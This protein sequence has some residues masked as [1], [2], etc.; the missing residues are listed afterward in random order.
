MAFYTY[1]HSLE[2]YPNT[3][4]TFVQYYFC[5]SARPDLASA[6][7]LT[8]YVPEGIVQKDIIQGGA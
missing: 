6:P 7:F 2:I 5:L 3:C 1:F 4:T 8:G